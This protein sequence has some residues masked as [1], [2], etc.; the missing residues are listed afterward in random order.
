MLSQVLPTW[1]V[2]IAMS[3]ILVGKYFTMEVWFQRLASKAD[4][5]HRGWAVALNLT[6]LANGVLTFLYTFL[7]VGFF[8]ALFLG[9]VDLVAHYVYGYYKVKKKIPH[10][11]EE[12]LTTGW[13]I[14]QGFFSAG[15]VGMGALAAHLVASPETITAVLK[16]IF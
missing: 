7:L 11:T 3:A 2:F 8:W 13:K 1:V 10:L 9:I 6:A 5:A 4:L 12:K 15:Y 16:A 14:V